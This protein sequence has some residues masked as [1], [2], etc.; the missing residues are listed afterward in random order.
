VSVIKDIFPAFRFIYQKLASR[1]GKL[2]LLLLLAIPLATWCTLRI[3][4]AITVWRANALLLKVKQLRARDSTFEDAMRLAH[5]YVGHVDYDGKPCSSANCS[6]NIFLGYGWTELP[7]FIC[8]RDILRTVGIRGFGSGGSVQVRDG[9]VIGTGFQVLTEARRGAPFGQ[10][11]EVR[12]KLT[13]HFHMTD[14]NDGR[15]LGLEEHPN[16]YVRKPHLTTGG[17]GEALRAAV[18]PDATS[19][20]IERAFDFRLSCISSL[21]GCS[22]LGDLLP[23]AWEDYVARET[24]CHTNE[25]SGNYG[26]CPVRSLARLARDM[27][28]VLLV[29]VKKVIPKE[30]GQGFTQDVEFQ[31]VELLKGQPDKHLPRFPMDIGGDDGGSPHLLVGLPPEIFSPGKRVVLF[32][33]NSGPK[34]VFV[35][36]PHCEVVQATEENLGV[37]RQTLTQLSQGAPISALREGNPLP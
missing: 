32:L 34:I 10:W 35:P 6:F 17:G 28:N 25:G 24:A 21:V 4:M 2:I 18:T 22:G 11:L 9:H 23:K 33:R 30:K 20:E 3:S 5:E 31:L 19:T 7:P 14:Y 27:D 37:V 16:H 13:D 1:V 36:Y 8:G 29:E 26:P 15:L 12:T